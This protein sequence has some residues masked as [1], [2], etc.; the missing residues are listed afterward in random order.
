MH[1]ALICV[2]FAT[3]E[4]GSALPQRCGARR[5]ATIGFSRGSKELQ[6]CNWICEPTDGAAQWRADGATIAK[7][8]VDAENLQ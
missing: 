7:L 3:W 8:R 6:N 2:A 4:W 5:R 1:S